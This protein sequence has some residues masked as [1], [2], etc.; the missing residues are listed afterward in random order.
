MLMVFIWI[1]KYITFEELSLLFGVSVSSLHRILHKLLPYLHAYIVPKYIKW[2]SM[3]KLRNLV[4]TYPDWSSVVGIVDCTP[5]RIRKPTGQFNETVHELRVHFFVLIL[6]YFQVITGAIQSLYYR[7]DR[8]C[9]FLNWLVI[10]DVKGRIVYSRSGFYGH[11]ND[12]TC[13]R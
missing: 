12:R 2:H 7:G 8:H 5:F 9:H 13:Y 3:N 1:R 10:I 6:H 4:G 11:L